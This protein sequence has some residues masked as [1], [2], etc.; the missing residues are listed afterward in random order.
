MFYFT[1]ALV[2]KDILSGTEPTHIKDFILLFSFIFMGGLSGGR[3]Q[4][5]AK[6]D[7]F[8][9]FPTGRVCSKHMFFSAEKEWTKIIFLIGLTLPL[10]LS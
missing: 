9:L 7:I 3:A 1:T 6:I 10:P 8:V 5:D 4:R 2:A